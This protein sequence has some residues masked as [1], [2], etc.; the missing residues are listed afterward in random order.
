MNDQSE[1]LLSSFWHSLKF[2]IESA[3]SHEKAN[4]LR[5]LMIFTNELLLR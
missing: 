1:S 2:S 3:S 5:S 4:Q